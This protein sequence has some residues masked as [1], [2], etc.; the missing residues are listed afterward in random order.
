MPFALSHGA[1]IYWRLDGA[2]DKPALVL[3]T[4]IGTDLSLYDPVVPLLTPDFR[5]CGST[6]AATAPP[7]RPR[8]TIASTCWPTTCWR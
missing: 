1:R 3:L 7:T 4:S 8:A 2:A 5:I 6:P